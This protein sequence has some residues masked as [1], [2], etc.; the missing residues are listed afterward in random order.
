MDQAELLKYVVGALDKLGIAYFVTGSIASMAYGEA[1]FTND[2]DIVADLSPE[3]VAPFTLS[4]PESDFYLS[5][6]AASEAVAA[7]DQFNIIHPD[8]G[9]KVDIIVAKRD[10]FDRGRFERARPRAAAE[11]FEAMFASPEDV[12]L[13]K[14]DFYRE[15]GSE[16]HLRDI[17]GIL[18]AARFPIDHDYIAVWVARLDLADVWKV[19]L[20][21]VRQP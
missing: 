16:K 15:G 8:S 11:N 2:I 7:R 4:F 17:A 3:Q 14:M 1:R 13:K 6:V 21:R 5:D 18:K 12:I 20:E 10:S 9:L 19:I